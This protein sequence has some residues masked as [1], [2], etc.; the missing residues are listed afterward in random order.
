MDR[1]PAIGDTDVTDT[2]ASSYLFS[3]VALQDRRK[4]RS[5]LAGTNMLLGAG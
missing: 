2:A 1:A 4:P 3:D 5:S